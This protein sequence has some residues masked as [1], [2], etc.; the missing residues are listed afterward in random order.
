MK[1]LILKSVLFMAPFAV[2]AALELYVLPTEF[3]TF[4]VWEAATNGIGG[5]PKGP[6]IPNLHIEKR[7]TGDHRLPNGPTKQVEW[8]TDKF[9]YRNRPPLR[10]RYDVVTIGDSNFAGSFLD[11]KDTFAE[12]LERECRCTVYNHAYQGPVDFRNYL[13]QVRFDRFPP[14]LIVYD[15]RSFDLYDPA[16]WHGP[17]PDL[18]ADEDGTTLSNSE[19]EALQPE[20]R[21][22]KQ[23]GLNWMRARLEIAVRGLP[24]STLGPRGRSKL[25]SELAA[26]RGAELAA[27]LA[28]YQSRLQRHGTRFVVFFLEPD[29]ELEDLLK[30]YFE[31]AGVDLLSLPRVADPRS[32]Y[33]QAADSHWTEEGVRAAASVVSSYISKQRIVEPRGPGVDREHP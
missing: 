5:P 10:E 30:P 7:E 6:F 17:L 18:P 20:S 21:Y 22:R 25:N 16:G 13:R 8:F 2:L 12:T 3:W 4:R 26:E 27:I 1:K 23:A 15:I 32:A 9:G 29:P 19:I 28:S 33:F 24:S 11:Q 31:Q 14:K